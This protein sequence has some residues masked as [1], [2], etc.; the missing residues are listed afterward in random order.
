MNHPVNTSYQIMYIRAWGSVVVKALRYSSDGP[1]DRF[2]VV[3]LGIFFRGSFR[4]NHVHWGR[5]SLWKWVPGI[6]PGVKAAG[7][8]GWR[9]TTLV[10]PK[11]K[12]TPR[13]TSACRGM[14]FTLVSSNGVVNRV[15]YTYRLSQLFVEQGE[16][17]ST[18]R[19]EHV[20]LPICSSRISG[21][22]AWDWTRAS[23]G[24]SMSRSHAT[25]TRHPVVGDRPP[26]RPLSLGIN[27]VKVGDT[28]THARARAHAHTEA[29]AAPLTSHFMLLELN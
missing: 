21:R 26:T 27:T 14:T 1:G 28:Y 9:P 11:V 24:K 20:R 23:S 25:A 12:K 10:V 3:S 17:Y 18:G 5:L 16:T 29:S 6:S 4:Q 2:P 19:E 22:Q 7:A 13:A 8:Y 15:I